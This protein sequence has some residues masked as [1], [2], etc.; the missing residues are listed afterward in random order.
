M[1]WTGWTAVCAAASLAGGCMSPQ[2]D[3]I[4]AGS[5]VRLEVFDAAPRGAE[6]LPASLVAPSVV[7]IERENWKTTEVLVP[8]DGTAHKPT[9]AR[10]VIESG[11][12]R[13]QRNLYP[14]ATSALE[15][16]GGSEGEQQREAAYNVV[17]AWS[18]V[19]FL[20]P[21]MIWRAPWRVDAS[22]DE[23]YARYWHPRIAP[24]ER[25]PLPDDGDPFAPPRP[26][27]ITP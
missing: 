20:L 11:R 15:L 3:R 4:T 13:R 26:R 1:K 24:G 7:S 10:R 18:D 9:Y 22:P 2:N 5:S 12:T 27:S 16:T 25:Q 17:R 19:L 14:T 6:R 23:A 21:R 8:V